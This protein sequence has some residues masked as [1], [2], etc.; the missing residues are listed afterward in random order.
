MIVA[1]RRVCDIVRTRDAR[2]SARDDSPSGRGQR[3][4]LYRLDLSNLCL[5]R[6]RSVLSENDVSG[7]TLLRIARR[8]L[9]SLPNT[10]IDVIS[11]LAEKSV[12]RAPRHARVI[13]RDPY[14]E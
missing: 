8:R 13:V 14:A 1:S 3:Q 9:D 7:V 11:R 2:R 6:R 4:R 10:V 5:D 12:L